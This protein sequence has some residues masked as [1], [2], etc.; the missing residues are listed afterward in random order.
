MNFKEYLIS[1][2]YADNTIKSYVFTI[3]QYEQKYIT[4]TNDNL[5]SFKLELIEK[6]K[7]RTVNLRISA[8]NCYI[9]YAELL[10]VKLQTVKYQQQTFLENVI[11]FPDYEYLKSCLL[12]DDKT[13]WYFIV[14]FL[15]STGARI[16]ELLQIKVEHVTIGY[17]DLYSKGGKIRRIYIPKNLQDDTMRWLFRN[18]RQTGFVFIN[19][20][21]RRFTPKGISS[22]LKRIAALYSVDPN[23]VHP[24]SFR[25]MFAKT[26][27]DRYNDIAL[28]AD[29]M[30]H[31]SIETTRIYLRKTA[32][33]QQSIVNKTIDW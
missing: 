28:L 2:N 4:Y 11:S 5:R 1:K 14:R 18:N 9:D 33:E 7:P 31:E 27:I 3:E 19:Q 23:V 16:S 29:L 13:M 32:N 21:G 30:G 25:H 15:G 24:H 17:V 12:K 22:Q 10:C 6:N 26:F 20:A 8:I